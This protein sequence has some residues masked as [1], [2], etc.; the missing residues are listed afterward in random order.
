[1]R[2][3]QR[4]MNKRMTVADATAAGAYRLQTVGE[5]FCELLHGGLIEL[6]ARAVPFILSAVVV[7]MV[8]LGPVIGMTG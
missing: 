6:D 8:L 7:D 1:M 5:S 3:V 2:N 4:E